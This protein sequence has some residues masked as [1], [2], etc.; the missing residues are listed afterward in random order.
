MKRLHYIKTSD[1]TLDIDLENGYWIRTDALYNYDLKRYTITFY[2][3][4]NTIDTYHAIETLN[5]EKISFDGNRKTIKTD[6]LQYVSCL[7]SQNYFDDCIRHC[8]YEAKCFDKG[9]EL[10]EE[11]QY[12]IKIKGGAA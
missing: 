4:E 10:F 5:N 7:L 1:F 9:N 11:E 3:K 12:N 6:I 2:I 8:E